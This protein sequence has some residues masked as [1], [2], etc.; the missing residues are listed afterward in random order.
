MRAT[1][2]DRCSSRCVR[3]FTELLGRRL[4]TREGLHRRERA[5]VFALIPSDVWVAATIAVGVEYSAIAHHVGLA[6]VVAIMFGLCGYIA[7]ETISD[8]VG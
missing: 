1:Y 6:V 7:V 3:Q 5:V 4:H 2:A 8:E